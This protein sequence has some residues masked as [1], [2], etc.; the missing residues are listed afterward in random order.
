MSTPLITSMLAVARGRMNEGGPFLERLRELGRRLTSFTPEQREEAVDT[1]GRR[2]FRSLDRNL[3][4]LRDHAGVD[5]SEYVRRCTR[6]GA[7]EEE[8]VA[9]LGRPPTEAEVAWGDR[10]IEDRQVDNYLYRSLVRAALDVIESERARARAVERAAAAPRKPAAPPPVAIPE[11]VL[12]DA[13]ALLETEILP[14]FRDSNPRDWGRLLEL[15]HGRAAREVAEEDLGPGATAE[16]LR[17]R[18]H[19][20]HQHWARA[21]KRLIRAIEERRGD[22]RFRTKIVPALRFLIDDRFRKNERPVRSGS[23]DR[24]DG[25][26]CE[27]SP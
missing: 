4:T 22:R 14:A 6:R 12:A 19:L 17:R 10:F 7:T 15:E 9:W 23:D 20:A 16:A 13:A 18:T 21:R 2:W 5:A 24:L 26:D 25:C 1:V 8:L 27:E 3:E 11:E